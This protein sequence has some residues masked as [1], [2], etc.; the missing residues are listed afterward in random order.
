M[1]PVNMNPDTLWFNDVQ[2]S[3]VAANVVTLPNRTEL[4]RLSRM[5]KGKPSKG[6]KKDRRLKTNRKGK[7]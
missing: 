2:N 6:T 4:R 1:M 5:A 7:K 3:N